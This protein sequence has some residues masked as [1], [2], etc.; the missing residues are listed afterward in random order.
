MTT[1]TLKTSAL[2]REF[3]FNGSLSRGHRSDRE[4][5][6]AQDVGYKVKARTRIYSF[7]KPT[8]ANAR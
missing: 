5:A 8:D 4:S 7:C 2:P 6:D 3:V 1:T